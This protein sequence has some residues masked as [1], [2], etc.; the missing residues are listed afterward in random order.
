[1]STTDERAAG[2]R[3]RKKRRTREALIDAALDLFLTRGYDAT[4]IDEIVAAVDVSQR[5]FFRYF[6]G[7]EDVALAFLTEYDEIF[8]AAVAAR[9]G[10]EPP[11]VSM[12]IALHAWLGAIEDG[13]EQHTSRFRAL[14]RIIEDTPVLAAGQVRRFCA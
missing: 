13:D 2:L 6:A 5:T 3:E 14:R 8:V 7:K 12:R 1:M 11:L 4:T 10:G 9:P